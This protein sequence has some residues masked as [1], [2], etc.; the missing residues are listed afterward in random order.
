ML[1]VLPP[2]PD[3]PKEDEAREKAVDRA[4]DALAEHY[5]DI[6]IF[7]VYKN[8]NRTSRFDKGR[9]NYYSRYGAVRQWVLKEEQDP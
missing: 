9:G 8:G 5:E 6:H 3:E 1:D 7:G 4:L 2:A